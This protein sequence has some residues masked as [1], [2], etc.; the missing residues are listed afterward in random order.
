MG[1]RL[2]SPV[3]YLADPGGVIHEAARACPVRTGAWSIQGKPSSP[4]GL[5]ISL[6]NTGAIAAQQPISMRSVPDLVWTGQW[7]TESNHVRFPVTLFSAPPC[8]SAMDLYPSVLP[9][10]GPLCSVHDRGLDLGVIRARVASVF[11]VR[12]FFRPLPDPT[13]RH[14]RQGNISFHNLAAL[15]PRLPVRNGVLR[16]RPI[17]DRSRRLRLGFPV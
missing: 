14:D 17:K 9:P 16:F 13:P 5:L 15:S 8:P 12:S 10:T 11:S 1:S 4:S 6:L 3:H 7:H 2:A